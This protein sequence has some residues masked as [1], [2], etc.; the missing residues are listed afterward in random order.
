MPQKATLGHEILAVI[1]A[2]LL[3]E[4]GSG[5]VRILH[6]RS[7][8]QRK[9]VTG[10]PR[11]SRLVTIPVVIQV[12][13]AARTLAKLRKPGMAGDR[14]SFYIWMGGGS[15]GCSSHAAS[16]RRE[17]SSHETALGRGLN[18]P[19]I[20]WQYSTRPCKLKKIKHAPVAQLDRASAF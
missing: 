1:L 9:P 10:L 15:S 7:A 14:R 13:E 20:G 4:G 16:N 18:M 19:E 17:M 11:V 3:V 8:T 5:L 2:V 12:L 6:G